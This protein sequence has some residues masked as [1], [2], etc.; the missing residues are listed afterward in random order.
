M[1]AGNKCPLRFVVFFRIPE[2]GQ[3]YKNVIIP[4][5]KSFT[6]LK[7]LASVARI[8][9]AVRILLTLRNKDS[10]SGQEL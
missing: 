1:R 6:F 3:M 5:F 10:S 2:D 9:R 7:Y 8:L 4:H